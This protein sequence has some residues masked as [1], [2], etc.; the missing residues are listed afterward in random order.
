[1]SSKV[2]FFTK[3]HR[4]YTDVH[5]F[6]GHPY[7]PLLAVSGIDHTIKILSS[8]ARAQGDARKGINLGIKNPE[9]ARYTRLSSTRRRR[10][11]EVEAS[12][13]EQ[14]ATTT[15]AR[16]AD[17]DDESQDRRVGAANTENA[18]VNGGLASRKRMHNS[19]QICSRNDTDR[20]MGIRDAYI[21]VR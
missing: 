5:T 19:Y 10:N 13:E 7:E 20:Q 11:A 14:E 16:A 6:I 18:R 1:M 9:P 21:T 17:E 8:D 12:P 15:G 4:T 2:R 3:D